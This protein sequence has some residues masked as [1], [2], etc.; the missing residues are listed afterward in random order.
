MRKAE[1]KKKPAHRGAGSAGQKGD[2]RLM[3]YTM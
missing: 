1:A 3:M 2:Q